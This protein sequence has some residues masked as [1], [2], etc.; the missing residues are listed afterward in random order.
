[1]IVETKAR[2]RPARPDLVLM[3]AQERPDIGAQAIDMDVQLRLGAA[4]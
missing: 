1:M 2:R 3:R 4:G